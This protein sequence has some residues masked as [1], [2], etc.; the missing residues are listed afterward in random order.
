[1][2]ILIIGIWLVGSICGYPLL[3]RVISADY[4]YTKRDRLLNIILS[5]IFSWYVV[6]VTAVMIALEYLEDNERFDKPAKW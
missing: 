3:K 4:T 2:I 1:M 5:A 6:V